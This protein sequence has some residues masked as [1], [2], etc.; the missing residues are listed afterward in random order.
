M[1]HST[2]S[3]FFTWGDD[4]A[5]SR[6]VSGLYSIGPP[7]ESC[8]P[9]ALGHLGAR[10]PYFPTMVR[11]QDGSERNLLENELENKINQKARVGAARRASSATVKRTA[12]QS[13]GKCLRKC[14]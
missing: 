9:V 6:C 13:S 7:W 14:E 8:S 11:I 2:N 1:M 12:S 4:T 10:R 3:L 5:C